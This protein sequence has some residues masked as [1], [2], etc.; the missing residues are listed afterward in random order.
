MALQRSGVVREELR[1]S[2]EF[3][4]SS[5]SCVYF[6]RPPPSAK[7]PVSESVHVS[8]TK[9]NNLKKKKKKNC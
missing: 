4:V 6:I 5:N 9:N 8:K 3:G 7:N 2:L 1:C